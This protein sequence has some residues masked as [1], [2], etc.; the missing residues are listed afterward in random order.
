MEILTPYFTTEKDRQRYQQTAN[1][2]GTEQAEQ[3]L[4]SLFGTHFYA[5]AW[6]VT[7]STGAFCFN[8]QIVKDSEETKLV[9]PGDLEFKKDILEGV[10]KKIRGGLEYEQISIARQMM[11]AAEIG[12]SVVWI[13]P[14]K[15][16]GE[17]SCLYPA[18]QINIAEKVKEDLIEMRQ[19]QSEY[20][21]LKGSE[22]F[23]REMG[24]M[25]YEVRSDINNLEELMKTVVTILG[26]I[27]TG[28]VQ[29]L[30]EGITGQKSQEINI[31]LERAKESGQKYLELIK[32]GVRGNQLDKLHKNLL[33]ETIDYQTFKKLYPGGGPIE[34]SC[35]PI[36]G[37]NVSVPSWCEVSPTGEIKCKYCTKRLSNLE[38]KIHRCVC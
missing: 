20:L 5:Q 26:K 38:T 12:A 22:R 25:K 8:Y 11:I 23:L 10:T 32:G 31:D 6:E 16:Q 33:I 34:T 21:D 2:V 19:F 1:L 37:S 7:K 29:G 3:F 28:Y 17:I 18:T 13:S 35:G 24:S 36:R 15:E 30:M 4:L 9:A 14:K 27:E